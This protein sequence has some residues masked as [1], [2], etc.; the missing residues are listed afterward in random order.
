MPKVSTPIVILLLVGILF[1]AGLDGKASGVVPVASR[2]VSNVGAAPHPP[3][4]HA[5]CSPTLS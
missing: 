4:H 5:D 1:V 3:T 2:G